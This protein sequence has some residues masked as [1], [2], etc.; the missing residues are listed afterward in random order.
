MGTTITKDTSFMKRVEKPSKLVT[1]FETRDCKY[2]KSLL[3]SAE[4]NE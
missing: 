3:S 2:F 1:L 4:E